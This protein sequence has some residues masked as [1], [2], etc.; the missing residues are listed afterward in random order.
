MQLVTYVNVADLIQWA[1]RR[2]SQALLPQ[3]VRQLVL[4][5][6]EQIIRISL[7]SGDSVQLA[8]WDGIVEVK[9]GNEFVP[10]GLSAWELSTRHDIGTKADEDYEKRSRDSKGIDPAPSTFV[11]VT[12]RRWQSKNE[13]AVTKRKGIWHD[14]RAYDADDIM[15]WLELAPSVHVWFS[16]LLGKHPENVIDV[17]NFWEDWSNATRPSLPPEFILSG[18]DEVAKQIYS[19]L[20]NPEEPIALKAES[21]EEAMAVFSATIKKLP[22][23]EQAQYLART[24]IVFD[25]LA[26]NRLAASDRHLILIHAFESHDAIPRAMRL[27]HYVVVPLGRSDST[28]HS[29]IVIPP[30]SREETTRVL[31]SLGVAEDPAH[32]LATLAR[33]SLQSFRRRLSKYPMQQPEWALPANGVLL[34]SAMFAGSW[35]DNIEG[36]QQVISK[37]AQKPYKEVKETLSRWLQEADPPVRCISTTWTV[38]SKEDIWSLLVRY[39]TRS[40]IKRFG[41]VFLDV[42]GSP[43]PRYDLPVS[44]RWMAGAIGNSPRYSS[45]LYESLAESLAIMGARSDESGVINPAYV[46]YIVKKLLEHANT[47]WRVWASLSNSLHFIAEAAPDEF[48]TAMDDGLK[49]DSPVLTNLFTDKEEGLSISSPHT[50]ILWALET[51]AWSP[52]YIGHV[53]LI[54][55]KLTVRD[56]GGKLNNRPINSLHDIFCLWLPQTKAT[57][58]QRLH[59]IDTLQKYEPEITWQLLCKLLP[60]L[61]TGRYTMKPR[62]RGW[63][64]SPLAI[65]V[66]ELVK[67]VHEVV[68]R[69]LACVDGN[70]LSWKN[71]IE[72]LPNLPKD[73]YDVVIKRL[74]SINVEELTPSDRATIWETLRKLLSHHRSFPKADWALSSERIDQLDTIYRRFE[75]LNTSL[76]YAWL[77]DFRPEFPEGIH[78][79]LEKDNERADKARLEA[80]HIIYEQSKL[81]GLL[82]LLACVMQPYQLGFSLGRSEIL[83]EIEDEVLCEYLASRD[84]AYMQFARG[85]S[86]G[87]ITSRSLEWAYAK[88]V[89][90]AKKWTPEQRAEFLVCLP[91]DDSTWRA[92]ENFDP[93]TERLYWSKVNPLSTDDSL[94][95]QAVEKLL[96]HNRPCTAATLIAFKIKDENPFPATLVADVLEKV[97]R[98][99]PDIDPPDPNFSYYISELISKLENSREVDISRIAS[100]EW[101]FLPVLNYHDRTPKHIHLEL[102]RNPN[103]FCELLSFVYGDEKKEGELSEADRIRIRI[104]HDLLLSWRTM[105]GFVDE[106]TINAELLRNWVQQVRE[107]SAKKGLEKITDQMIGQ[108]L[109]FSPNGEDGVWPHPAVC[110]VIQ[111]TSNN[112]LELGFEISLFNSRKATI[113]ELSEG[114]KQEREIAYKYNE[115]TSK[116]KDR[117]PRVATML[118]R[119]ANLYIELARKEDEDASSYP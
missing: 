102:A 56:P 36:D 86:I 29:T 72:A 17:E 8:G 46:G 75:P 89:R 47:D 106:G 68:E 40:D 112:D 14:V 51:L 63:A 109:S 65:T 52:E 48:L 43:D 110:E 114:G 78:Y 18:R 115:Y 44:Q 100:L 113:R 70:G 88:L 76:K 50:G 38:I 9:E 28:T 87:R 7:P 41:D 90:V 21:R 16:I 30:L 33:D 98:A 22:L 39:L 77:F 107:L 59:V 119:I 101:A 91:C 103:F 105:P 23:N 49:G 57:L 54:L 66:V 74:D 62:W 84:V 15:A 11:F 97:L 58:E 60:G 6:A 53:A 19:W 85:F 4:A 71:L 24:I 95:Q 83:K 79:N 35:N 32:D 99:S 69:M 61:R 117:W 26:W 12:P 80:I 5:S 13:W 25:Q 104:G 108:V 111:E 20:V 1:M 96:K 10:D 73:S 34:L 67:A 37:L 118:R 31:I 93:D 81:E 27:G 42:L 92:I 55:A 116:I 45:N 64:E 82:Q 2:D 94:Y 3:L